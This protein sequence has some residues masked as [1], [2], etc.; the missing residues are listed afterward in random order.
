MANK[1]TNVDI[2]STMGYL[3]PDLGPETPVI[4]G[5]AHDRS[6]SMIT[7]RGVPDKPGNAAKCLQLLLLQTLT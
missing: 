4:S 6:E 2:R 3:F 7:L 1:I 5:V